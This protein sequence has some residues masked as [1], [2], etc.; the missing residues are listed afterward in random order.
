[1]H[2]LLSGRTVRPAAAG[3]VDEVAVGGD[4]AVAWVESR[5]GEAGRRLLATRGATP[6]EL[7]AGEIEPGSLAVRGGVVSWRQ[8]GAA[9]SA[10]VA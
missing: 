8:D 4:G 6:V 3:F 1:V 10:P 5:A 2:D 7:A 9:R